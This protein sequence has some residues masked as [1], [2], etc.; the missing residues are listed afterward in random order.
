VYVSLKAIHVA[1]VVLS[2][3]GLVLRYAL[4]Q[5]DRPIAKWRGFRVIPH[6]VDTVLLASAIGLLL[7]GRIDPLHTPWLAAK[8]T[9]LTLY[10]VAGA[11]ALRGPVRF[12]TLAIVCA[13]AAFGYIVA[14]AITKQPLGPFAGV[15]I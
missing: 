14:V 13:A 15:N 11:L 2:G 12:R 7:V 1:A 5:A 9:G 10:I 4:V 8:L 3:L 6:G